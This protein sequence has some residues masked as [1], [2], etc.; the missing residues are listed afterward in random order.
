MP[1]VA[2]VPPWVCVPKRELI[3]WLAVARQA[4]RIVGDVRGWESVVPPDTWVTR[5]SIVEETWEARRK[6]RELRSV[7]FS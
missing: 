1:F 6:E 4:W 3:D 7:T 2:W 5:R